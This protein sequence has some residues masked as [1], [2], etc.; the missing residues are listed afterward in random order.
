MTLIVIKVVFVK[1]LE[2]LETIVFKITHGICGN[3]LRQSEDWSF[4][5]SSSVPNNNN[6]MRR[7]LL[8]GKTLYIPIRLDR[9]NTHRNT[10][11]KIYV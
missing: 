7:H 6:S 4:V 8:F 11:L 2:Q 10:S 3:A 1:L 9:P 5:G